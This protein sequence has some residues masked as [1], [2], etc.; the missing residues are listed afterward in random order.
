MVIEISIQKVKETKLW[1]GTRF[2]NTLSTYR[3]PI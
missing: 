3:Y 2:D 1:E